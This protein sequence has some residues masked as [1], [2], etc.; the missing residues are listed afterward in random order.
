MLTT[1]PGFMRSVGLAL[2]EGQSGCFPI[3]TK[4]FAKFVCASTW[5]LASQREFVAFFW[6]WFTLTSLTLGRVFCKP[7]LC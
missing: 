4:R 5:F 2:S 3:K 6:T 7:P 1:V